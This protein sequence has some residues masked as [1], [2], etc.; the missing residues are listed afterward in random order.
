MVVLPSCSTETMAEFV[1]VVLPPKMAVPPPPPVRSVEQAQVVP[2]HFSICP[3]VQDVSK[4]RFNVP[5]VPPPTKPEFAP[6]VIP[7]SVP[8]PPPPP[9][10]VVMKVPSGKNSLF[11]APLTVRLPVT[12]LSPS[13][14]NFTPGVVV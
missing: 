13:T 1:A 12:R 10:A 6:V 8:L 9:A 7:V 4:L 2:F 14:S 3:V 11:P 5:D